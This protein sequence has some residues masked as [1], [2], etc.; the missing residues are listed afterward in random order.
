MRRI[1]VLNCLLVIASAQPSIG[2]AETARPNLV[3]IICDDLGWGDL[4]C[5]G[6]RAIKTPHINRL[7]ERGVRFTDFY[8]A[9]IQCTPSRAGMLTGRYPVRFGLTYSLMTD[10]GVGIPASELLLPEVLRQAG[11]ATMLCGKW[12]LGDKPQFH[13]MRHGFARFFGLLRGH[14]TEPREIWRDGRVI[15]KDAPID[16]LT[17]QYTEEGVKFIRERR[18]GPFF[19]ML[20]HTSPH[21][22]LVGSYAQA[23]EQIDESVG[24]IVAALERAGQL[25]NTLVVFTSDN[26]P[27]V[28]QAEKGG[29]TGV[30]RAGK[31]STFEGGI[32]VPMIVSWKG[33]VQPRVETRPGILLDCFPTF[34]SLAAGKLPADRSIDGKDLSKVLLEGNAREGDE[35]FFYFRDELRACRVGDWK[36]KLPDAAGESEMLFDL[37]SDPS[38]KTD[39]AGARTEMVA[40]MRQRMR[41]FDESAKG[42]TES[43]LRR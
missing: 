24:Q 7:A 22:P 28:D 33:K 21:V 17:K 41:K 38:E 31:Y 37:K 5:Y 30:L 32:R 25:E 40:K 12:H 34:A 26:G 42:A 9:G 29:S 2:A 16:S 15:E 13:P 35:F 20:A 8:C 36:L 14:D 1:W 18:D 39:L 3:L 10:A 43:P 27:A 11:Y 19:L 6:N 4:G 23:L